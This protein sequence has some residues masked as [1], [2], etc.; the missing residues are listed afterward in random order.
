MDTAGDAK[1]PVVEV[2]EVKEAKVSKKRK[3]GRFAPNE[4]TEPVQKKDDTARKSEWG[5]FLIAFKLEHPTMD[6]FTATTEA[7]KRYVPVNGKLKS[8]QKMYTEV[9]KT[10]HPNWKSMTAEQRYD[11]IR[12][13]FIETI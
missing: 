8:F 3:N 9:W 11:A 7:R 2:A 13:S 5:K 12:M 4:G 6:P 1:T 10:K